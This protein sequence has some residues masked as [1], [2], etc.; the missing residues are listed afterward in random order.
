M[1]YVLL[2]SLVLFATA[3]S[4]A[5]YK[6]VDSDGNVYYSDIPENP[7]AEPVDLPEFSRYRPRLPEASS[8]GAAGSGQTNEQRGQRILEIV[9]PE[10]EA[11]IRN[12]QG[13]VP[14]VLL[15][16]P[17][18]EQGQTLQLMLDGTPI[19]GT[20]TN[21]SM[22]LE[23]VVRGPHVLQARLLNEAGTTL[24]SS[25][26]IRFYMRQASRFDPQRRS[27]EGDDGDGDDDSG[28]DGGDDGDSGSDGGDNGDG[29]D[30]GAQPQPGNAF[31]PSYSPNYT[32]NYN[33]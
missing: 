15:V 2:I 10:S 14:V 23:G 32:P 5:V 9:K 27:G 28:G 7:D 21:T 29:S 25:D 11:T 8:T 22:R 33:R 13:M 12:N 19:Q 17:D 18:L 1:R 31:Q 3:L 26:S 24:A 20:T 4:A 30:G 16:N 6:W